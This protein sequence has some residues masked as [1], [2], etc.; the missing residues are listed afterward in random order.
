MTTIEKRQK[1]AAELFK[2]L[3]EESDKVVD[4]QRKGYAD[5]KICE[6]LSITSDRF[7][8]IR[9]FIEQTIQMGHVTRLHE[10]GKSIAEIVSKLGVSEIFAR[11]AINIQKEMKG[12]N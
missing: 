2:S 11:N 4:L 1:H 10:E 5:E 6:F 7:H 12:E 3:K 8:R 9:E